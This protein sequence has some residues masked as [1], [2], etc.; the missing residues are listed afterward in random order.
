MRF[1]AS[2]RGR[3]GRRRLEEAVTAYDAALEERTREQ[4]PLDWATSTGNQGC[5]LMLI[6]ERLSNVTKARSAVQQIKVA[7]ATIQDSGNAPAAAYYEA[8]LQKA[9]SLLDR[10]TRE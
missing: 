2:E 1:A 8:Q 4:V 5:A 6:A 3:A 9:R 10:L 7:I